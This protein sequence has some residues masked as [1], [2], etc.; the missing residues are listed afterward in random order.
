MSLNDVVSLL[1]AATPILTVILVFLPQLWAK[2]RMTA[3]IKTESANEKLVRAEAT[4]KIVDTTMDMMTRL[5]AQAE[6]SSRDLKLAEAE[7]LSIKGSMQKRV[8][9]FQEQLVRTQS[10]LLT[11]EKQL[12]DTR[13]DRDNL[14]TQ[15]TALQ[16][17][18]VECKG[19]LDSM[20]AV[21]NMTGKTE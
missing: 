11:C 7:N 10:R 6:K 9:Y 5:E 3:E 8:D 21:F 14:N 16:I 19:K 4:D 17:Q 20:L 18:F 12:E 1:T 15:V 13:R 2:A